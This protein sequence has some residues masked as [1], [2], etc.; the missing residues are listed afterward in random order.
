VKYMLTLLDAHVAIEPLIGIESLAARGI[1]TRD[2]A[3]NWRFRDLLIRQGL[4]E[5]ASQNPPRALL[6]ALREEMARLHCIAPLPW[7]SRQRLA[8]L[9][10]EDDRPEK[11]HAIYVALAKE[12]EIAHRHFQS[13]LWA[14][15]ALEHGEASAEILLIQGRSAC[16]IDLQEA[17]LA[18]F[19]AARAL[20]ERTDNAV[21][22]SQIL[23]E[24][25]TALDWA[26]RY[27]ESRDA[28]EEA[29]RLIEGE[30]HDKLEARL[31]MA[32]GRSLLRAGSP[33]AIA[34]LEKSAAAS[35]ALSDHETRV[36]SLALL[37]AALV[38][39]GALDRGASVL[40]EAARI[41]EEADDRLHLSAALA[42]R[43]LLWME[44]GDAQ[45][46]QDDLQ[47]ARQLAAE[48]GHRVPLRNTTY[49]LAEV[50]FCRGR[51][52]EALKMA[53]RSF[54]LQAQ[55]TPIPIEDTLLLARIQL[56]LGDT[57]KASAHI[58]NIEAERSKF[59]AP[60][61]AYFELLRKALDLPGASTWDEVEETVSAALGKDGL[62]EFAFLRWRRRGQP[63]PPQ[64]AELL[65][66]RPLWTGRFA[67][68]S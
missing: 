16:R 26:S 12:A 41:C 62:V 36:V 31:A 24:R 59:A 30:R 4:M 65:R 61:R 50:L 25:A 19:D 1:L 6:A 67:D 37:G 63:L 15:K 21:M 60:S 34:E 57:A 22:M 55:V 47:R 27:N 13:H 18:T 33:E 56:A 5:R 10:I 29:A 45:R 28:A 3:E 40:D 49:N 54:E 68:A 53:Q 51:D 32:K 44:R 64:Y 11:A 35:A 38:A 2:S 42:N 20:A 7:P 48:L 9:W 66:S 17:A 23:L 8:E 43:V 14:S 58:Q 46:G 52:R 39:S